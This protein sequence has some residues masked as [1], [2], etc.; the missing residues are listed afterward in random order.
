MDH[1]HPPLDLQGSITFTHCEDLGSQNPHVLVSH[2]TSFITLLVY[3]ISVHL[4]IY[5]I[6]HIVIYETCI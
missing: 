6:E 1:H 2:R 3:I 5:S 4:F